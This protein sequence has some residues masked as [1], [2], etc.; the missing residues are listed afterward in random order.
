MGPPPLLIRGSSPPLL[1]SAND[2]AY[3]LPGRPPDP[4]GPVVPFESPT[5]GLIAIPLRAVAWERGG[6]PRCQIG[7]RHDHAPNRSGESRKCYVGRLTD[8]HINL[9]CA[10]SR[11]KSRDV[12]G[13]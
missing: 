13:I 7:D 4:A 5:E 2:I 8:G 10:P 1:A 3:A 11:A 12:L 6:S 9:T